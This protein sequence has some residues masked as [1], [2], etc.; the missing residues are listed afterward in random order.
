MNS[1]F[2]SVNY[3]VFNAEIPT[4]KILKR[5]LQLKNSFLYQEVALHDLK[6]VKLTWD[7]SSIPASTAQYLPTSFL[8]PVHDI[9]P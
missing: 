1:I 5:P 2:L 4:Y 7:C 9:V 6:S 8:C 3:F